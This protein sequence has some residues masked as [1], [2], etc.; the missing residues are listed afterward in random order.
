MH[1]GKNLWEVAVTISIRRLLVMGALLCGVSG[2]MDFDVAQAGYCQRYP[3]HCGLGPDTPGTPGGYPFTRLAFERGR[4]A[5]E[6]AGKRAWARVDLMS[7]VSSV[8]PIVGLGLASSLY[9]MGVPDEPVRLGIGTNGTSAFVY[10][11]WP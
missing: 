9:V 1:G 5:K 10:G 4:Q 11:R 8:L 7:R 6:R 3:A 2:C